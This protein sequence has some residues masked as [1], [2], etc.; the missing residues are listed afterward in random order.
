MKSMTNYV[1]QF[2][3]LEELDKF[4]RKPNIS[5]MLNGLENKITAEGNKQTLVWNPTE[6]L[7]KIKKAV[8]AVYST[9][10]SWLAKTLSDILEKEG[11]EYMNK[12][13]WDPWNYFEARFIPW[14]IV[15]LRNALGSN[16]ANPWEA[17]E[18]N[19]DIPDALQSLIDEAMKKNNIESI[20]EE[21]KRLFGDL[22]NVFGTS[23]DAIKRVNSLTSYLEK[24]YNRT[25]G[26]DDE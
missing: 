21:R 19:P 9:W 14:F 11:E 3:N 13:L 20:L 4:E 6:D 17:L 26:A 22:M 18:A 24:Y 23:D 15:D 10:F 2:E 1:L 7:T 8:E 5:D 16:N 25:S 12:L